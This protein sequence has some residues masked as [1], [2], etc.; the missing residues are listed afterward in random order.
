MIHL[1]H[2]LFQ[3]RVVFKMLGDGTPHHGVL[4]HQNFS[5]TSHGRTDLLHL[6]G[7]DIVCSDDETFWI[8]VQECLKLNYN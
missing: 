4:S 2:L 1:I 6:F 5:L 8:F 7:R 3:L